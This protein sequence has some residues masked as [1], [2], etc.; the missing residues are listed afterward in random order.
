DARIQLEVMLPSGSNSGIYVMG[1]YELQMAYSP[2]TDVAKP[3]NMD[4]GALTRV[5]APR[6]YAAK[7]PGQWQSFDVEF[8]APRF[9]AAGK[10]TAPARF[11]SVRLNGKLLHENVDFP[12]PTLG[13]LTG[14]DPAKGPLLLQGNHGPVAFRN[15]IVTP[16]P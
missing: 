10:K 12:E 3:G 14:E 15:I 13:G 1:E 7:D 11:V 8:R 6:V 16:R 2:A 9:D 4:F 5:A